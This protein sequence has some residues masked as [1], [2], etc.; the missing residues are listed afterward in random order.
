MS[1][2]PPTTIRRA[3]GAVVL[4]APPKQGE[5]LHGQVTS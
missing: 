2:A 4:A 3:T 1:P 5:R